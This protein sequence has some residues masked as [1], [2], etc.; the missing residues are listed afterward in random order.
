MKRAILLAFGAVALLAIQ[1]WALQ[2]KDG[3]KPHD[4][5][6]GAGHHDGPA[7]HVVIMPDKIEWQDA[8]MLPPGAKIA[9]LEG[10]PKAE[11]FFTFRAKLPAGYRIPPHWHPTPE[12]LTVLSGTLHIGP[13]EKIDEKSAAKLPVGSYTVMPKGVRHFAYTEGATEIQVSSIGP[14][15]IT[16]VNPADDPRKQAA[17]GAAR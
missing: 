1:G 14:W 11:G 13:G 9:V 15:G 12:R 6:A 2:Q 10:D 5:S 16:Y 17:S 7:E 4:E 3:P 8:K